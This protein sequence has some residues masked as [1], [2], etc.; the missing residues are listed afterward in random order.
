[1]LQVRSENV[2]TLEE[3]G[4]ATQVTV[5]SQVP[6]SFIC[7]SSDNHTDCTIIVRALLNE[8]TMDYMCGS[9]DIIKQVVIGGMPNQSKCGI[10]FTMFNWQDKQQISLLAKLDRLYDGDHN[11][12]LTVGYQLMSVSSGLSDLQSLRT[13]NVS[14]HNMLRE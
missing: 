3:G 9:G 6:P 2:I 13:I 4:P 5:T 11:R 1:M 8:D 12:S 14:Q 7:D 10:V